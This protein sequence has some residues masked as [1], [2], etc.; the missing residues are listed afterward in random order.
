MCKSLGQTEQFKTSQKK[1]GVE[2]T[3][4]DTRHQVGHQRKGNSVI[5]CNFY[6]KEKN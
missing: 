5:Q 2:C 4:F 6:K 1:S 3:L